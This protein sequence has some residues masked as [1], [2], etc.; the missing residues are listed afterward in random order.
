MCMNVKRKRNA[1]FSHCAKKTSAFSTDVFA[2]TF[3]NEQAQINAGLNQL[4][5]HRTKKE[6][7]IKRDTVTFPSLMS[8]ECH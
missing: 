3:M 2:V 7:C 4:K 1:A 6:P 8:Y 5:W